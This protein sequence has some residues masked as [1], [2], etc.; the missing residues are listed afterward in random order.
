MSAGKRPYYR[1]LGNT[2]IE[3]GVPIKKKDTPK[4]KRWSKPSG[5]GSKSVLYLFLVVCI[6]GTSAWLG[7]FMTS[8]TTIKEVQVR[9]VSMLN[10]EVVMKA[11]N[12]PTGISKDSINF[13]TVIENIEA[14]SFVEQA[15]VYVSPTGRLDINV[16]ERHPIAILVQGDRMALV[17][18][19]GVKMP[20]PEKGTPNIPLL[21]GFNIYPMTTPVSGEGFKQ[22]VAFLH[23]LTKEFIRDFTISEVGW[24]QKDG[25]IA[26]TRSHGVRLTFGKGNYD[27]KLIKWQEFYRNEVPVR[28]LSSF[29]SLD[30]RFKNQIVAIES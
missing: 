14:I 16:I 20:L 28:G 24:H 13:I 18:R 4:K 22:T 26:L 2:D 11:A 1:G 6:L 10:P 9:G 5:G 12:V 3:Y 15:S 29:T 21:Y 19:F 25:V 27:E 7:W 23:E 30:F 8:N 17:D